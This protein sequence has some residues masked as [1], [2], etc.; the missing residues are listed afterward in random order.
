[1]D[2]LFV[3]TYIL[4]HIS[5]S[6][7]PPVRQV[8][9]TKPPSP[10][11]RDVR[12]TP[13]RPGT[14]RRAGPQGPPQPGPSSGS[15]QAP[16][17]GQTEAQRKA[18][19]RASQTEEQ[20]Q[21]R[22]RKNRERMAATRANESQSQREQRLAGQ[23]QRQ[24]NTR[25]NETEIQ[26]QQRREADRVRHVAQRA[27]MDETQQQ[28][29]R[30]QEAARH[31]AAFLKAPMFKGAFTYDPKLEYHKHK[32]VDIGQIN[33]VICKKCHAQK[34]KGE[35]AGMCCSNGKVMIDH[36][37]SPPEPLKTLLNAT[38]TR[39]KDFRKNLR[40]YNSAFQMT[41]IGAKEMREPG[42]MPTYRVQ[43]QMHHS[44]G[45]LLPLP[46]EQAKFLQLYFVGS[47]EADLRYTLHPKTKIDVILDLQEM[48]HQVNPYVKDFKYLLD[49]PPPP[50]VKIIIDA[51]KR[52]EGVH[53]GR[54]NAPA[55]KEV[56]AIIAGGDFD[57]KRDII[58]QTR[59]ARLKRICETHRSYDALQYPLLLP[60]GDDGYNIDIKQV[61][62][63]T[64]QQLEKTVSCRKFYAYH[65]M[66]RDPINHLHKAGD[67]FLQYIVDMYVK[68]ESER[69]LYI[70]L[71]QKELRVDNYI[72]LRD[73]I[74]NDVG[75]EGLGQLVILPSSF[76]GSPR[77]MHER[78]QDCMRY[79]QVYGKPHFFITFTCNPKWPEIQSNLL[80]GQTAVDRHD[81]VARVFRQKVIKMMELLRW[82]QVFG[83][84]QAF[85]YTVEWQKR[86]EI[87][88][89][90]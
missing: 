27:D 40:A 87:E 86:G 83:P 17:P 31:R 8:T 42:F 41:S 13:P 67:L 3:H 23:R 56:A 9:P 26:Q 32:L 50:N 36:P 47:A 88:T 65:L 70:K 20:R 44:I 39:A 68:M 1:M 53:R 19:Y 45:S 76:T 34:F 81:L 77:Y 59:D 73:G 60:Y 78:T 24:A 52:P 54:L 11:R 29:R 55:V 89:F 43:G 69:L 71:H 21:E 33:A 30:D 35:T 37:K 25:A 62:P 28:Q 48:L 7:C 15:R 74:N 85:M 63:E 14:S 16:P 64:K 49:H 18:A 46:N 66:I 72:H 4:N 79:V 75:Q 22:L 12:P 80:P 6:A 84:L 82:S 10:K 38:T 2:L 51:N 5:V 90:N 61:D 57:G 58:L